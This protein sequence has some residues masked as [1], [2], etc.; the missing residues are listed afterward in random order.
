MEDKKLLQ[1]LKQYVNEKQV[2]KV[3]KIADLFHPRDLY[4]FIEDWPLS[5]TLLL[6]RQLKQQQASELFDELSTEKQEKIINAF[7]DEEINEMFKILYVD[8]TVDILEEL[9]ENIVLKILDVVN[10]ETRK[11]LNS[12]LKYKQGSIGFNMNID[13]VSIKNSSTI[14]QA[15]E[16]LKKKIK[17]GEKEIVG[18][19]FVHDSKNIFVGYIKTYSLFTAKDAQKVSTFTIKINA[20]TTND[21]IDNAKELLLEYDIPSVPIVSSSGKQIGAIESEDIIERFN[22]LD[23][24]YVDRASVVAYE[25]PY[26]EISAWE[27]FKS[28]VFWIVLLIVIGS[29]TQIIITGFQAIWTGTG[30][31]AGDET[32]IGTLTITTLVTLAF[33]T[34]ISVSSSINDAAGNTGSQTSATLVRALALGE[35]TSENYG[36]AIIKETTTGVYMGITAGVTALFR[37]FIIWAMFGYLGMADAFLWNW[38]FI[39]AG[40]ASFSFSTAIIV[41]NLLG[42]VIPI[43]AHKFKLD[44]AIISGPMQTTIIDIITFAVYL[45]ITTVIFVP[46]ANSGY[47]GPPPSDGPSAFSNLSISMNTLIFSL[48]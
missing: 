48:S 39:I 20:L 23:E 26:M 8:E 2:G 32:S 24:A 12:V 46:L 30:F 16:D 37:T 40:I 21:Y 9:P 22:N 6:I 36:R 44:G 27:L 43:I 47:F 34:A 35:V 3:R 45:G 15:K 42:V 29:F 13:F 1:A 17:D 38:L 5:D 11:K 19:I 18:N 25:K 14:K 41:G 7:S 28:R 31:W 33:S 4:L 10:L